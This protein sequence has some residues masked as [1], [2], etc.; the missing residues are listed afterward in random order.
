MA[1]KKQGGK[2]KETNPKPK[3]GKGLEKF[4]K[5]LDRMFGPRKGDGSN[6]T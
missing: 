5:G 2:P 3:E 6:R 4:G 1:D